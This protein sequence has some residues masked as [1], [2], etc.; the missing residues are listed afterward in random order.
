MEIKE[1]LLVKKTARVMLIMVA[2]ILVYAA[3]RPDTFRVE[4]TAMIK[5]TPEK[6]YPYLSDFRKGEAWLPYEKKDPSM[7]RTHSGA[8]SG[9]G[10]VYEFQG[11]KEVGSG[12]LEIIDAVPLSR[13]VIKL[14]MLKPIA[15][16]DIIEYTLEPRGDSTNFTWTI[17]GRVPF[18]G[19]VLS[20]FVSMDKM[21]GKDFETGIANLKAIVEK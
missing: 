16:H 19:K 17:H 21:I 15:G 12:R 10:S 3:T 9:K 11:N 1:V 2:V 13:V 18:L 8:A 14:D 20:V 7:K 6:I 5:A 4:R